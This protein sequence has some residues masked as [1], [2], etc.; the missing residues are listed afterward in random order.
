MVE[1]KTLKSKTVVI[2]CEY[3]ADEL[4]QVRPY[5]FAVNAIRYKGGVPVTEKTKIKVIRRI[6]TTVETTVE[7]IEDNDLVIPEE[8]KG[9][10]YPMMMTLCPRCAHEYYDLD[11]H[12]IKRVNPYQL[13]KDT[14]NKCGVRTG[15]DYFIYSKSKEDEY[16]D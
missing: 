6:E 8:I 4:L 16:D 15:W 1:S 12:I 5:K 14:C 7:I 13:Y 3:D 10:D 2:D 11:D 9:Y